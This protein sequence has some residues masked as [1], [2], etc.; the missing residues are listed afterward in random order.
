[1]SI[2]LQSIDHARNILMIDYGIDPEDLDAV[3]TVICNSMGIVPN[4][5][6]LEI[7]ETV[8][9]IAKDTLDRVVNDDNV[10]TPEIPTIKRDLPNLS[11]ISR[12]NSLIEVEKRQVKSEDKK[13]LSE[14]WKKG[15]SR[16]ANKFNKSKNINNA[17]VSENISYT[18]YQETI[19]TTG[20]L[21]NLDRKYAIKFT[22]NLAILLIDKKQGSQ[23]QI[24]DFISLHPSY[25]IIPRSEYFSL[26]LIVQTELQQFFSDLKGN[27]NPKMVDL[28]YWLN[29]KDC[30]QA[31]IVIANASDKLRTERFDQWYSTQSYQSLKNW[32]KR[33]A[34][35]G[36]ICN[37]WYIKLDNGEKII[38]KERIEQIWQECNI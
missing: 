34:K 12:Q 37:D 3:F 9:V 25:G 36:I 29:F 1:M 4:L 11:K 14:R 24:G 26:S 31:K 19:A 27:D 8:L 13:D 30:T 38:D 32:I 6:D 28:K 10:I 17:S 23:Y 33:Q 21:Y 18:K 5:D 7:W 20:Y 2:T 16:S 15:K 22:E 35:K